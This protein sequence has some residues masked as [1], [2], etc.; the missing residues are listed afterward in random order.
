ME[1]AYCVL[2]NN[3]SL[4]SRALEV[5]LDYCY[6]HTK[7]IRCKIK[8]HKHQN[9]KPT[10]AKMVLDLVCV[11]EKTYQTACK[12]YF[13]RYLDPKSKK[14]RYLPKYRSAYIVGE[15][16]GVA[17]EHCRD[18]NACNSWCNTTHLHCVGRQQANLLCPKKQINVA[19]SDMLEI[20]AN[21]NGW[22]DNR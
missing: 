18:H 17:Y 14:W 8:A 16:F 2:G 13:Y 6:D 5:K 4:G 15:F 21:L 7:T 19:A 11:D 9:G 20:P 12:L 3:K 10:A 22:C 1:D